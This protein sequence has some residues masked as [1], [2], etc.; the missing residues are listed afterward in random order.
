M[1]ESRGYD[2]KGSPV[3]FVISMMLIGLDCS[4]NKHGV[5]SAP[6]WSAMKKFSFLAGRPCNVISAADR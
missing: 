3:S 4:P 5:Y 6:Y 2:E 1:Q